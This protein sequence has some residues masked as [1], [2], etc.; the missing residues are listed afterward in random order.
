MYFKFNQNCLCNIPGFFYPTTV[1]LVDNDV[2]SSS[3]TALKLQ[4]QYN[5]ITYT[6]AKKAYTALTQK[7]NQNTFTGWKTSHKI[8]NTL[9]YRDE[10]YNKNRFNEVL[11]V[12]LEYDMR[13]SE[14]QD[15][16]YKADFFIYALSTNDQK[17]SSRHDHHKHEYILLTLR[18]LETLDGY[19]TKEVLRKDSQ[20]SKT[21]PSYITELLDKINFLMTDEFQTISHSVATLLVKD[22]T[23]FLN[24]GNFL[25]I[26]NAYLEEHKIC[27]G[28]L[29]D[30]QG[31]L[32]LL[33][34][35]VNIHWLFVR[36]E[37]GIRSS[38]NKAKERGAPQSVIQAL[39]SKKFILSLY[40]PEDFERREKIDWDAYLIKADVFRDDNKKHE[41][42]GYIPSDYYYAFT[43]NFPE[44]GIN[45]ESIV[46][47]ES[48]LK[49][50]A[51]K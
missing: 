43:Q 15:A 34:N 47:Y 29:F 17:E 44:H 10:V 38:I 19:F 8:S 20:I 48:F 51:D 36:N 40:E 46:S 6:D 7:A 21:N 23:S 22:K 13:D 4:E 45:I 41:V 11:I 14:K 2:E 32:V 12:V 26:L 37:T 18:R 33:D 49:S 30:S 50:K 3:E 35:K 39:E 42:F 1:V 31:S 28:Y 24:D 27:E 5:V 25:P 9:Q 16:I